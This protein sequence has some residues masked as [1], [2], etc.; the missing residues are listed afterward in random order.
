MALAPEPDEDDA[1]DPP[2]ASTAA[3]TQ[4]SGDPGGYVD[5]EEDEGPSEARDDANKGEAEGV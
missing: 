2:S 5:I 1:A 4:S 3:S